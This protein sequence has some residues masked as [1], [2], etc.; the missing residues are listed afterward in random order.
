MAGYSHVLR[1]SVSTQH[2]LLCSYD[3]WHPSRRSL[4]QRHFPRLAL[5]LESSSQCSATCDLDQ[6]I[7][8]SHG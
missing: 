1:N 4:G 6:S 7:P 3:I 8:V 5:A 2:I